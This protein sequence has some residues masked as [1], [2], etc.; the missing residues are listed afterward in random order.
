M[1]A[2]PRLRPDRLWALVQKKPRQAVL[3]VSSDRAS[4]MVEMLELAAV[5]SETGDRTRHVWSVIQFVMARA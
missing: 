1:I 3:M 2:F 4:L 5:Q